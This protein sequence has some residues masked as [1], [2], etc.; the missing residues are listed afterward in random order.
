M[1]DKFAQY[2][3]GLTSPATNAFSITPNDSTD[4]AIIPRAFDV[5]VGGDVAVIYADDATNATHVLKNRPSGSCWPYRVK[6]VLVTGTT[7]TDIKGI[8]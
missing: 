4:L 1:T 8:Y 2:N 5:G 7:A 3:A 6:R